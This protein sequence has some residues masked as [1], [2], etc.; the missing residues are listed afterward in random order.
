[1][2]KT[3]THLKKKTTVNVKKVEVFTKV[4]KQ[5]TINTPLT[6]RKS[7]RIAN[8]RS[9][10]PTKASVKKETTKVE[11]IGSKNTN[12][13]TPKPKKRESKAGEKKS[14]VDVK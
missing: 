9:K 10:T 8:M 1:M 13:E 2:S 4:L 6:L 7:E 12:E 14:A 11:S 5:R 3:N